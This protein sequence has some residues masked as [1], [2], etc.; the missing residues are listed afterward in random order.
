MT[1]TE[2][3]NV[4]A[5]PKTPAMSE[6]ERALAI[7]EKLALLEGCKDRNHQKAIRAALRRLGHVGG[8]RAIKGDDDSTDT[9][10]KGKAPKQAK[11]SKK[12]AEADD[13]PPM[14]H[15]LSNTKQA[16]AARKANAKAKKNDA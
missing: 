11:V 7:Q 15:P 13:V 8:L 12:T 10:A 14:P 6:A 16:K 5:E 3:K 1:T 4:P 9:K 2:T